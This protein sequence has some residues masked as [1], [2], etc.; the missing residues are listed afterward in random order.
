MVAGVATSTGT[1]RHSAELAGRLFPCQIRRLLNL[2]QIALADFEC[3]VTPD[4][5]T[6]GINAFTCLG[7]RRIENVTCD[8]IQEG[9]NQ[10]WS[11]RFQLG[12]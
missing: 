10:T 1:K 6:M 7:L 9:V 8:R 3:T 2:M 11:W 5:N 4:D 12:A